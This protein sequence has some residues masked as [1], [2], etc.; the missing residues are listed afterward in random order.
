M[1]GNR[2]EVYRRATEASLKGNN[3]GFGLPDAKLIVEGGD[4]WNN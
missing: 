4:R 3:D 2:E 1:L